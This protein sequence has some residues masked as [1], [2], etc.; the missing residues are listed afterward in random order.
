MN[1]HIKLSEWSRLNPLKK[2]NRADGLLFYTGDG[3][4]DYLNLALSDGGVSLSINLGSGRLDTGISPTSVRFDDD[5]WHQVVIKREAQQ[6]SQCSNTQDL[7][8][9]AGGL[10]KSNCWVRILCLT[11]PDIMGDSKERPTYL[12]T[13]RKSKM[14]LAH[15][16]PWKIKPLSWF[17]AIIDVS[18]LL[19]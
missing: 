5:R 15:A 14:G 18:A 2:T 19:Y 3:V 12:P 1:K 4:E 8:I 13:D 16:P 6:V 10:I 17:S 7:L 9:Q 11:N